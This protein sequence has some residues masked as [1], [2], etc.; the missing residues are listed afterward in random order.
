MPVKTLQPAA[1]PIRVRASRAR[2]KIANL[3]K[4]EDWYGW[5]VRQFYADHNIEISMWVRADE[6]IDAEVTDK[7]IQLGLLFQDRQ[8]FL[9]NL[10]DS[11]SI[12]KAILRI[13]TEDI[14]LVRPRWLGTEVN[15][16]Q[17]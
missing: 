6:V 10:K 16:C 9:E 5:V 7:N 4:S 15:P 14:T 3:R 13:K 2:R 11:P 12:E 8:A 17:A 1:S